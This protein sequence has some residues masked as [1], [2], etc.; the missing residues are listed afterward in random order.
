V[1][2]YTGKKVGN[3][4][5]QRKLGDGGFA[6]VYMGQHAVL[7]KRVAVKFLLEEWINEPDVVSRFF[8]EARTMERLKDHPHIVEII[9]IATDEICQREGV[10]PYFIMEFVEGKS[11]EGL[12]HSDE[13]F[14]LDFILEVC[15]CALSALGH[16]HKKNVV[17]R[18]V[19]PS[20]ILITSDGKVKLTDFGIA[21]AKINT[22]KT[23]AGLT[24]GSTDYMSPE[25]AL[26]KRDLDHRS[27]I[28]SFGV[29]MYEMVVGKLPFIADN[30]NSVALM[31]IQED[32]IPPLSVNDAVPERLN[33]I[34]MKAMDK[35]PENRFQSCEEMLEAIEHMN[36]PEPVVDADIPTLNIS[37]NPSRELPEDSIREDAK[38]HGPMPPSRSKTQQIAPPSWL[39]G[40]IRMAGIIV[41]FILLFLGAFKGYSVAMQSYLEFEVTPIGATIHLNNK[42]LGTAESGILKVPMDAGTFVASFSKN[43]FEEEAVRVALVPRQT[44]R[45]K[46]SLREV[47]SPAVLERF[48]R[49]ADQYRAVVSGNAKKKP[50]LLAEAYKNI[51]EE[52]EASPY[53]E[54]IH[55]AFL[56]LVR[57][58]ALW[59][60][61]RLYKSRLDKDPTDVLAAVM[62]ARVLLARGDA[63]GGLNMLTRA[64]GID[65]NYV[66]MLNGLGDYY[67]KE[68]KDQKLA[69][70][71]FQMSVYL[72]PDQPDILK[73]LK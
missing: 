25:Q 27:D 13:A 19:K 72:K 26:G 34:I 58:Y 48:D 4:V 45:I 57:R 33:Y 46:R 36:E 24:L 67:L 2:D 15:K 8:D 71:Y 70:Q 39:V 22:S 60:A 35:K 5:V 59:D 50:Q 16:C 62:L 44:L 43:G 20:N 51:V 12:I 55:V 37:A 53:A 61:E 49:V 23:G 54:E 28:Y 6:T 3:Y 17:H 68:G 66:P 69:H 40:F 42:L 21:K 11:L 14:T 1:P 47:T 32:A 65:N 73:K 18:D 52:L 9:D 31:H 63:K 64:W 56:E 38:E 7:E 30:P 41:A 10:S 29:T